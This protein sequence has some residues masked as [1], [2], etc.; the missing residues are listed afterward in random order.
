MINVHNL[1]RSLGLHT[2][3]LAMNHLGDMVSRWFRFFLAPYNNQEHQISPVFSS[4][5]ADR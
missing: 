5:P 3:G 1:E 2:Y 4:L